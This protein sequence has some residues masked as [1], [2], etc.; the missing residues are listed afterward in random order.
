MKGD[1]APDWSAKLKVSE[2]YSKKVAEAKFRPLDGLRMDMP[3][4]Q[5]AGL[6][7]KFT[8][9]ADGKLP[10]TPDERWLPAGE[11][12]PEAKEGA[13]EGYDAVEF[14]W[15]KK[16]DTAKAYLE[17][18]M[19]KRKVLDRYTGF[20]P[21]SYAKDKLQEYLTASQAMR[22]HH[23]EYAEA[24]EKRKAKAEP[25]EEVK[26][27]G[28]EVKVEGDVEMKEEPKDEDVDMTVDDNAPPVA[29]SSVADIEDIDGK[30][31]PLY[32]DFGSE[33]WLL[34]QLRVEVSIVLHAFKEDV[35]SQ[36]ADRKAVASSLLA[37]YYQVFFTKPLFANTFG[38]ESVEKLIDYLTGDTVKVADGLLSPVHPEVLPMAAF[39]KATEEARREREKKLSFGDESARLLFAVKGKGALSKGKGAVGAPKG[40]GAPKGAV[41]SYQG[42]QT[43]YVP[44]AVPGAQ[45]GYGKGAPPQGAWGAQKRPFD[46]AGAAGAPKRP[47]PAGQQFGKGY[48]KGYGK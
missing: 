40:K 24:V 10:A 13:G 45:K 43:Q 36:D 33:D 5:I 9:P 17:A 47:R 37:H 31:T 35:T 19:K 32:K 22:Q 30:K 7:P 26:A 21:S 4:D 18:Y 20:T 27:E 2:E 3:P 25:K 1:D 44:G 12:V 46:A 48:G 8:L 42:A 34:L 38:H 6:Y 28:E 23:S 16:R 11:T 41:V 29:V 39:V 14:V 15:A